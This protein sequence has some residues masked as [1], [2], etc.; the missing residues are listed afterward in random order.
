[1][2]WLPAPVEEVT[3]Y[4]TYGY[5]HT[6]DRKRSSNRPAGGHASD[7]RAAAAG[8]PPTSLVQNVR[9]YYMHGTVSVQWRCAPPAS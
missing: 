9:S 8:L 2:T 5:G 6:V 7:V 4:R 3:P 1:M